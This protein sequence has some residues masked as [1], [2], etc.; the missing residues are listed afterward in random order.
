M[1]EPTARAER[2]I[3]VFILDDHRVLADAMA[4]VIGLEHNMHVV[5]VANSCAAARRF[6]RDACP[7]VVLL[8][9]SLPD[10]D[11]LS[12]VPDLRRICS[13]THILVLTSFADATTLLRAIEIGVSGF[14]GKDRPV[15]EVLAAIR[16]AA[17]GEIVMPSSLLMGL[18]GHTQRLRL[19]SRQ[20][21]IQKVL[22]PRQRE[23]LALTAQGKSTAAIA[24]E[25]HLSTMTVRT[26]LRNLMEKFEVH[27]R[28]EAVIFA[29]RHGLI[30][31]Q[32]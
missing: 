12:F 11:G 10:C 2:T 8:D 19:N 9:V 16:Q 32:F 15:S 21:S 23:I 31:S 30:E 26:H 5:G 17:D 1:T 14:V 24:K 27:S 18:L 3:Q 25:L 22:T 20:T 29:H 6:I 28:L 7:D 4:L 13:Q